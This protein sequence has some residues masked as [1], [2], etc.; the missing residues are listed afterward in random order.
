MHKLLEN[1]ITDSELQYL[2]SIFLNGTH[3]LS[4]GMDKVALP[5]DDIDFIKLVN[6]IIVQRLGIS[7]PYDIV[8][9]NFYKHSNSYFPHCDAIEDSA[10]LNIVIPI[11]RMG[12]RSVQ[13]FIVF[14]QLWQG[15]NI[16]WLGNYQFPGDFYSNKKT[17]NR[18]CDS[19]FLE[20]S[21]GT[22]LPMDI[23]QHIEQKHFTLDYFHGLSGVAYDWYPGNV[24]VFDSRHPHATGRMQSTSKLGVSIRI[25]HK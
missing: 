14:D 6:D 25:A 23:W 21:T 18:P 22:A 5:L 4:N 17:N 12:A 13:K 24:L 3:I 7:A 8:G 11:S 15:K 19:E 9:D 2:E 16:T 10:W 1:I 20:N